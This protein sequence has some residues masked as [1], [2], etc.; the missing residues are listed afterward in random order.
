MSYPAAAF[1]SF[2]DYLHKTEGV[3][4]FPFFLVRVVSVVR[5]KFFFLS[6]QLKQEHWAVFLRYLTDKEKRRK[7]NEIAEHEEGIAMAGEMLMS[8]SRD[9]VER[10]RLMSEYKYEVDTQSKVVE[11]KREVARKLKARNLPVD[12]IAEDTGLSPEEIAK[13]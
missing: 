13:L 11:A 5:G 7:I 2:W 10:A 3:S 4:F 1:C 9:E 8:I 12:Q 6:L